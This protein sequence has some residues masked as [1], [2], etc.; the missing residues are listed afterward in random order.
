MRGLEAITAS[1]P[2][3][4]SESIMKRPGCENITTIGKVLRDHGYQT[5]FL[6]GGYG[7]FDNMNYFYKSNGFI[8]HDRSD[9]PNPHFANIW[10]VSDEDLFNQALTYFDNFHAQKQPFFS[11]IMTTS[12]HKPFTFP[13]GISD[14][15]PMG[16][17]RDAGIHYADYALG[18]WLQESVAHPWYAN[19]LFV[20]V[21]D[22]GARVY[23]KAEI[24]LYSYEI[25]LLFL[26]PQHLQPRVINIPVSQIDIA[27]TVLGLLG[28]AYEAPFFGQNAL[29]QT[30][31]SPILLFNH[32]YDVALFKGN[33]LGYYG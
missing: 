12:N 20:I 15:L 1:F 33:E 32:N 28:F 26:S 21:A 7:Y 30:N 10:G 13:E 17:G 19:T 29:T 25:P 9:I 14:V 2:P 4:P 23:G 24:P 5:S 6:Y 18:R 27:P 31:N 22:H 8:T 3:I 16:G 11:I